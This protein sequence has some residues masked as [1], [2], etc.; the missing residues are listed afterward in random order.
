MSDESDYVTHL[1]IMAE[2][3]VSTPFWI[4]AAFSD[5]PFGGNP[6][7][8]AL[9]DTSISSE[10]IG[11]LARNFNQPM[12]AVVSP[13]SLAP[14]TG[15]PAVERRSIRFMCPTGDYEPSVCGH[16]TLAAAKVIFD[17][18][19]VKAARK[20][21]I[22]FDT[23][24][25]NRLKAVALEGGWIEIEIPSATPGDL[26]D[27]EKK[28]L[29]KYVDRAFGHDVKV[30]DITTGGSAYE[31][32]KS[33]TP[34]NSRLS[35]CHLLDIM[36]EIDESEDLESCVLNANALVRYP[37]WSVILTDRFPA[38]EWLRSQCIHFPFI[39]SRISF[40][41]THVCAG[42]PY[43]RRRPC[44]RYCP[45]GRHSILVS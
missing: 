43:E 15:L 4:I 13:M 1:K 18:P 2:G 24:S 35:L 34:P 22:H 36:T 39:G 26:D 25:G 44:L 17:L 41:Y 42:T 9:V 19:E 5:N 27:D 23:L 29:K 28:R 10:D 40:R 12:L 3:P 16:A 7:V 14:E 32:C 30:K 45:C 6:A 20:N 37:S 11:N 21:V 31:S 33:R 38:R 8:V